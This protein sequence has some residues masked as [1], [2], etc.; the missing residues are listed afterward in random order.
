MDNGRDN[1]MER[2]RGRVRKNRAWRRNSHGD[3]GEDVS[4]D[5]PAMAGATA[6]GT[7][8]NQQQHAQRRA[9]LAA[10]IDGTRSEGVEVMR[11]R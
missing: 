4:N 8:G 6:V 10:L 3:A 9:A 11:R 5:S 1:V 2:Y 7:G